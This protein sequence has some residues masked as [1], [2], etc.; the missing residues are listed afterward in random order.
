MDFYNEPSKVDE[1]EKMCEEYD[2]SELHTILY[3]HLKENSTLLELGCGPG[4][5]IV[6]LQKKYQVTGSDLSDEFILR[7]K[8]KFPDLSFFKLDAVFINTDKIFD[9]L[10]SNKVLHHFKFEQLEASLKR[11][12]EVIKANGLFAH[13]FWLGDKEFEMEGMF[14]LFYNKEKLL[15]IVSKYYK[16]LETY[17]YKEFEENDSIFIIAQ[18]N[19]SS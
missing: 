14:F 9:C 5:D 17:I 18:N 1:Y 15:S 4:N 11:Q 7:C 8:K 2:G 12:K 13:T 19:K 6:A 3:K 16:I 10:F